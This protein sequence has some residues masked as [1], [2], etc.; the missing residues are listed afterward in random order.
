MII[1][2]QTI[3]NT[4]I[5]NVR[6]T[7]QKENLTTKQQPQE[8]L[9]PNS[10]EKILPQHFQS[11]ISFGM[12]NPILKKSMRSPI[13]LQMKS[14]KKLWQQF[15][16]LSPKINVGYIQQ[17]FNDSIKEY[18]NNEKYTDSL[19][20]EN[21]KAVQISETEERYENFYHN[22]HLKWMNFF[23]E[24]KSCELS[25]MTPDEIFVSSIQICREKLPQEIEKNNQKL[26][27]LK[28]NNDNSQDIKKQ[29]D[30]TIKLLKLQQN[31]LQI[32]DDNSLLLD[33]EALK[34]ATAQGIISGLQ[35]K[36]FIVFKHNIP[37]FQNALKRYID[38]QIINPP[39]LVEHPHP[40]GKEVSS[41]SKILGVIPNKPTFSQCMKYAFL[42]DVYDSSLDFHPVSL[43]DN[44]EIGVFTKIPKTSHDDPSFNKRLALMR[45]LSHSN[46]CTKFKSAASYLQ[47]SDFYCFTPYEGGRKICLVIKDN[48]EIHSLE[49]AENSH[50]LSDEV[51]GVFA[52]ILKEFPKIKNIVK[53]SP[54]KDILNKIEK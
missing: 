37:V 52:A 33:K 35:N 28:Q 46:W 5:Y 16:C 1:T 41:L 19:F 27:I 13:F 14:M 8:H 40:S 26:E 29:I 53:Q 11:Q 38:Y 25:K 17:M 36:N 34:F 49:S 42:E 7:E 9:K 15:N 20:N 44:K 51:I 31:Y 4:K 48:E 50:S 21:G 12:L 32:S 39:N 2:K 47:D 22:Q 54:H 45:Y 24:N 30:K 10:Y 18:M 3:Q 43:S 23:V 6:K